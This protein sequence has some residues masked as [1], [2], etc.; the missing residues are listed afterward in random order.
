MKLPM[1]DLT[2]ADEAALAGERGPAVRFAMSVVAR[3]AP[4]F[5]ADELLDITAA[6]IDSTVYMGESTLEFAERLV[7]LGARV[8]VPS[9]L[10]VSG[11]DEHGW[12]Q[13]SVPP[14]WAMK[15]QRQ[16][17][18]YEAMGCIPTWT[19]A[20][21]QTDYS[22]SFGQQ[23][24]SGESNAIVYF[25]SV[26]GARTERYPDLL[27]IC[28]AIVGRVPKAGL[29]LRENRAGT[30]V[31]NLDKV[32]TALAC[33][34]SL[35]PVLGHFMGSRFA[36]HVPVVDGLVNRPTDDQFKAL[37]AGA[38]SSGAT[39]MF[40][41]VGHTP[42]APDLQEALQ[43]REVPVHTVSMSELRTAR[44]ELT[45]TSDTLVDVVLLGSPHFSVEE[46]SRLRDLV[47]G[48]RCHESVK[49]VVTSSRIV[50]EIAARNGT[51]D[52]VLRFG[53]KVTV[54]T[55]PLTTPMFGSR[56]TRLMTNS[57]KYAYYAPGLLKASV[58]YGSLSDCVE[59]AVSGS[60]RIDD[61][62]WR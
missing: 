25:N 56:E 43:G 26:V 7:D 8:A 60:I 30:I 59:T 41:V 10:N 14:D 9:T 17:R 31:L 58:V 35:Y 45:T 11:V 54:D 22:P 20:P 44:E 1:V 18:A 6:H 57:A 4:F 5:G 39:A 62:L 12:R 19:C 23:I 42:E 55:C 40:H 61:S 28:A 24:A 48:R 49:L 27:D 15:A 32:P 47:S 2:D 53:G 3:M 21:Y 16:M 29:H 50:R 52:E 38:A 37:G 36:G 34:D 46:F 51:L 33:D 13:W